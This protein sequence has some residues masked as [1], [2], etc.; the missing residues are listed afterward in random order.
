MAAVGTLEW[1]RQTGGRLSFRDRLSQLASAAALQLRV[2][3]AQIRW[4]LGLADAGAL[5]DITSIRI[6]DSHAARLAEEHCREV[7]PDFLVHHCLRSYLFAQALAVPCQLHPDAELLYVM[8]LL[9][10]LGLTEAYAK[11]EAS[12]FAVR[13]AEGARKLMGSAGY[14]EER[15]EQ[16]AEAIAL[17]LNVAV[18]IDDGVE[19]LLLNAGTVLDVTGLRI[20]E[21]HR[22]TVRAVVDRHPRMGLKRKLVE[23]WKDEAE[24]YKGT[25]AHFLE[26]YLD[27]SRRILRAPFSE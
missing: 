8:S 7:S 22:K 21:L 27:F 18:D 6:P 20:W 19:A 1:G 17:H 10:D 9:H 15:Q 12:C 24:T 11:G 13:G 25:R 2:A 5:V 26:H 14:T 4:R 23:L 3:P 16:V